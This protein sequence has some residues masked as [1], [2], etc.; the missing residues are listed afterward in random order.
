MSGFHIAIDGPVAA[1]KGTVSKLVAERLGFLYI[2]T[3]AMYRMTAL[4]AMRANV[5]LDDELAVVEILQTADID[6]R[7]PTVSEKDGRLSTVILNGE[8]VSWKIRTEAVSAGASKVA[9][10]AQVRERLV[11]IQQRIAADK[12]VVMEGRDISYKVLP[13]AQLKIYLTASDLDRAQRRQLQLQTRG[14]DVSLEKV[15]AELLERD[16]QDT[17]RCVD[18]LKIVEDAWVIDSTELSIDQVAQVIVERVQE[19]QS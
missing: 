5:S 14:I 13:F 9:R 10:Y 8:D 18:P 16:R 3:G 19:L 2:D 4:L 1:G 6:M 15:H 11:A 7:N 12:N 17:Q